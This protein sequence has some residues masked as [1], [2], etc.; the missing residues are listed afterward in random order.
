MKKFD[1]VIE[2]AC[3]GGKDEDEAIDRLVKALCDMTPVSAPDTEYDWYLV[4]ARE[5][6]PD[7]QREDVT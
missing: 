5:S 3:V 4:S 7:Y 1:I 6:D 2:F